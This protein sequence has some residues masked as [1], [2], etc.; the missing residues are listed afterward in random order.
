MARGA[1][2]T[3]TFQFE[4]PE[5]LFIG[6]EEVMRE[7]GPVFVVVKVLHDQDL[8]PFPQRSMAEG[9]AQVRETLL[10]ED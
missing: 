2:Y 6:L 5:E 7:A 10:G 1:G 4:N 9:W 8:P 3:R